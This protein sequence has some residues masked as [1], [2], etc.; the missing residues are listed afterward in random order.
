MKL[1]I[2]AQ[3][4]EERSN[5]HKK[6]ETIGCLSLLAGFTSGFIHDESSENAS[7]RRPNQRNRYIDPP[8]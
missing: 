7:M 2:T 3:Q 5:R 1:R 8:I 4:Q 6:G